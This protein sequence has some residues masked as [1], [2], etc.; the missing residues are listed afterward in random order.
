MGG[1]GGGGLGRRK[2]GEA[3]GGGRERGGQRRRK[4]RRINTEGRK[5]EGKERRETMLCIYMYTF[6]V[7]S[8]ANT[9][10]G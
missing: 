6:S 5:G 10:Y 3:K 2:E 4:R 9:W 1:G 8:S 7:S